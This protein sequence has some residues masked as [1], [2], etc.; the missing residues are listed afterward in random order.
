MNLIFA[1]NNI[2]KLKQVKLLLDTDRVI[3]PKDADV[4]DFDVVEDGKDLRENAYKKAKELYDIKK[5]MVFSD[6]TGLFVNALDGRPGIYSHRYAGDKAT[7][8]DNRDKL[9]KELKNKDDMTAYF[10]TVVCFID[11]KGDVYYFEGR[12]DGFISKEEH[13][14]DG[15]G[16][17]KIFYVKDYDKTLAEMDIDFKNQISHRG[18][19]IKNF[20]EFLEKNY[21]NFNN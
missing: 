8:K 18:K 10:K 12:L 3:L 9:L 11:N 5:T 13:G 7:D 21:E 20:K 17:D 2:N 4:M 14:D 15:F 6:D 1:S 19:A 16:Y